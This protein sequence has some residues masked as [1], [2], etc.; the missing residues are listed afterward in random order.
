MQ[1]VDIVG[2][3]L[4]GS[5]AALSLANRGIKVNLYEMRPVMKTPVHHSDNCAE[6]VCSNSLKSEKPASAAGMLKAELAAMDSVLLK[7]AHENRVPAG[8]A[9]AVDR[10]KF[11]SRITSLIENHQNINF[12]R[13]QITEIPRMANACI[14]ASGPLTSEAL[15]QDLC[16]LTSDE[17]LAFYDAA[18]PIVMADSINMHKVFRQSRY[19]E[20]DLQGDYLNAPFNKDEYEAFIHELINAKR[21]IQKDFETKDLFMACQPVEE[22]ARRGMD[23]PRYGTMKPVGLTDP[24]TGRRPWAALQ[25]RQ[26]DSNA[27][28]YNLV[29]FQT[30]LTFGE[31]KRVFSMIPGLE[32]AEFARF[33]VMHRNTFINAP[34]LLDNQLRLRST[35]GDKCPVYVAGQLCGTEGY[36][37]AIASG[38]YTAMCVYAH[39]IGKDLPAIPNQTAFGSLINYATNPDTQKYQPMHVNFGIFEPLDNK[40]KNKGLRYQEYASRGERAM[41]SWCDELYKIGILNNEWSH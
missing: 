2:G 20:N 16:T 25:L 39:L 37:E 15:T 34:A 26:E 6:L 10:E 9:L 24:N 11:S 38:A 17:N 13:T 5:E 36:T 7:V 29:G 3:G 14:L 23:A 21:V 33:G 30:N 41:T 19:E 1:T 40:I 12:V 31:Q 18:A 35:V 27:Q 22:I 4:A 8:G 28:S 32:N